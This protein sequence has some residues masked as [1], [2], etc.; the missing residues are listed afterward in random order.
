V[1]TLE[2]KLT[3]IGN[4]QA[5]R[6]PAELI[7][8]YNFSGNLAVELR[9]DGVL[10]K[11]GKIK[12]LSWEQTCKEMAASDEDWSDWEALPDGMVEPWDD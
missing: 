9:E 2:L 7:K 11:P 10:L 3:R 12:K 1:K 4:S 5:V 6:L 8:R